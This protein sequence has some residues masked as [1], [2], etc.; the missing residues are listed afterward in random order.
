MRFI[1][2]KRDYL[3]VYE[4]NSILRGILFNFLISNNTDNPGIGIVV[5]KKV[6]NAVI[7]NLIKRRVKAFLR[8]R[9]ELKKQKFK[10]WVSSVDIVII[11]KPA[12]KCATW[13]EI[14]EELNASFDKIKLS[15]NNG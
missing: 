9:I 14:K 12:A 1:T 6:G 5:S 11:S 3:R 7:R 2:S 10:T 15:G 13:K 8:E 4:N